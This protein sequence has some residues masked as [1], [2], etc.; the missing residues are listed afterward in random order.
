M[1]D[2]D[3]DD[4]WNEVLRWLAH[5][6]S[7]RR[8]AAVCLAADPS[9]LDAASFHCQQAVEK[10]LKG[11][12]V[13]AAVPFRKTHDLS[14]LGE[15]VISAY[16]EFAE[17]VASTERWTAWN[18]AYRYPGDDTPDLPPSPE[19]LSEALTIID[20]LSA[21]VRLLR[22]NAPMGRLCG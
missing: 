5:A 6:D 1:S 14:E 2:P 11:A 19:T 3:P 10:L 7:D 18:I 12:L 4:V 8:T 13:W 21:L 15:K 16:P 9:L 22:Q 20:R 17:F